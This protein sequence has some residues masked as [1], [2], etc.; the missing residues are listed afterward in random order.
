METFLLWWQ[1]EIVYVNKCLLL[2]Y[3]VTHYKNTTVLSTHR[4][5]KYRLDLPLK[6]N[7]YEK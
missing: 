7:K 2:Q 1:S 5:T 4:V 6:S 3:S